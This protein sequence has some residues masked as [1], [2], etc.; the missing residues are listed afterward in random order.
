MK[1]TSF[2]QRVKSKVRSYINYVKLEVDIIETKRLQKKALRCVK[3][4]KQ[5]NCVFF[6]L[7]SAVWKYDR[8]FSM[9]E[10]NDRFNPII[11]VCPI[12]NQGR[13]N[14]LRSMKE[15]YNFFVGK[16]YN[17]IMAYDEEK[18]AYF[19]ARSLNPDIIFYTNPYKGRIDNRYF[20]TKFTDILTVYVPYFMNCSKVKG[21]STNQPLHNLVWRK[22]AETTYELELAKKEQK[23][24]GKNVVYTGY[25]GID[26]LIDKDYKPIKHQWKIADSKHKRII[27]APHHTI[28]KSDFGHTCFLEY[29]EFMVE[30]AKKYENEIQMV[31]KPHPVLRG[32]LD[33][34]WGKERTDAYYEKWNSM[35]NTLIQQDDYIDLF[36]TSDAMI[37][38]SG[39]F[40]VEYLYVNKPVMRTIGDMTL[41]EV[42]NQFG[43]DCLN[44]YYFSYTKEEV[45]YFIKD[46]I[47]NVDPLKEQRTKFVNEVLM[48]KGSPSKNIMNDIIDSIDN[49]ILYR[50]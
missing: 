1:G 31:F 15:C 9:M 21:F 49:Q 37:H 16:G 50:N 28:E 10:K 22:Y 45:E 29:S 23:R 38:D 7:D 19:D 14:M 26:L 20:I 4:K 46:V 32:K 11:L 33:K 12:V 41:S 44:Q 13:A 18:D 34:L 30:M 35:P 3:R 36:L 47:N 40:I 39:S 48:P 2:I 42:F 8:I 43:L 27:W 5:L 25:P 6:A 17:V 24:H